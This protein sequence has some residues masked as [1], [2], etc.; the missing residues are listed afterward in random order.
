MVGRQVGGT[1]PPT[2]H[3][4]VACHDLYPD[5]GSGGSGRYVYETAR[6]LADRGHDV[7]V[8]T[9]RR[10]DGP[11]RERIEGLDVHRYDV[12]I[13]D[14]SAT[15]IVPQLPGALLTVADHVLD[16]EP[17]VASFQGPVTSL[18]LHA[19]LDPSVPRSC[20]F[21]SPWPAEYRLRTQADGTAAWRRWGNAE[22]RSV[23]EGYLLSRVDEVVTLSAY[24]RDRLVDAY[25]PAAPTAVVPGG[26]DTDRFSPAAGDFAGIDA[27]GLAFLT[28]RRLSPRMGLDRLLEA[29]AAVREERPDA[30][31]YLAG[32]G[33]LRGDLRRRAAALGL[34]DVTFL[35]YVPDADLPAAYASADVFVLPTTDLEGFGLATL[36]A[37]ASGL[38]VVGTPVGGTVE[39]LEAVQTRTDLPL[40]LLADDATAR[41][42]ADGMLAWAEC[43]ADRRREAG[44]A[45]RRVVERRYRW[46]HTV[47]AIE[48]GYRSLLARG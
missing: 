38:P 4:L 18:F 5:P 30:H 40:P 39:L 27:D 46:E 22:L 6:R 41:A 34:D 20:T 42:L 25:A 10:G 43:P 12:A 44:L 48:A 35:G 26:V 36:E 15:S 33:P 24:M 28:V 1:G 21:H 32:D 31:L 3:L 17:D 13:A 19:L 47:D 11:D 7:A 37:L 9:R 8:L 14:R 29:F 23:L 16:L 45:C 2:M